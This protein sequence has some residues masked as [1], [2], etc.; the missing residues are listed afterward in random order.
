M[1]ST[2]PEEDKNDRTEIEELKEMVR[3]L[4]D[5]VQELVDSRAESPLEVYH[6]QSFGYKTSHNRF[7]GADS[8]Q[9]YGSQS[10]TYSASHNRY[11]GA[12]SNS[13]Y[14][15]QDPRPHTQ[16]QREP[17]PEPTCWRCGQLGHLSFSCRVRI[18]H[19]NRRRPTSTGGQQ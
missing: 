9:N 5:Q 12:D 14:G 15:F 2:L 16:P 6:H 19:L 7:G 11:G 17:R 13:Q 4:Q 18:D 3:G 10:F 8:T 1:D